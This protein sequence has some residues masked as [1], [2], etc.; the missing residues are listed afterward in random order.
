MFELYNLI[1][2]W[3]RNRFFHSGSEWKKKECLRSQT[4][5]TEA[6]PSDAV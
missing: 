6:L 2:R 4:S 5:T 1:R 3:D